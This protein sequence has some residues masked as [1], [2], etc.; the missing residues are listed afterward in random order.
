LPGNASATRAMT[1]SGI[2]EACGIRS[3]AILAARMLARCRRYQLSRENS[4][5]LR[6]IS[7]IVE[8]PSQHSNL[9]CSPFS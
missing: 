1:V 3:D 6:Q 8:E 7:T 2:G 5:A 4:D 9:F